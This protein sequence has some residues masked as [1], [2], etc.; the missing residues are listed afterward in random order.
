MYPQHINTILSLTAHHT[1]FRL[2]T[3][4]NVKGQK[5]ALCLSRSLELT[6]LASLAAQ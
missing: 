4:S 2:Q 5:L 6:S 3:A 1:E